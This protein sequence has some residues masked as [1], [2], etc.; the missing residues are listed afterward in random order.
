MNSFLRFLRSPAALVLLLLF[1]AAIVSLPFVIFGQGSRG[2]VDE[3]SYYNLRLASAPVSSLWFLGNDPLSPRS[4]PPAYT[5]YHA[6]LSV[7]FTVM[8]RAFALL[9]IA[10]VGAVLAVLLYY[11]LLV[12]AGFA[13]ERAVM[14]GF[15]VALTPGF[16]YLFSS[17]TPNGLAVAVVLAALWVYLASRGLLWR[18]LSFVLFLVASLF[19][20]AHLILAAIALLTGV[21]VERSRAGAVFSVAFLLAAV[22]LLSSPWR[23]AGMQAMHGVSFPF[24]ILAELG[25]LPGVGVF[26]VLTAGIGLFAL[27]NR[28]AE[29]WPLYLLLFAGLVASYVVGSGAVGYLVFIGA[30]FSASGIAILLERKWSVDALKQLTLLLIACGFLFSILSF[31][32]VM[33]S[34]APSSSLLAA[35]H[36]LRQAPQGT[37]LSLPAYGFVLQQ[38]AGKKVAGD[39]FS[40]PANRKEINELFQLRNV[41]DAN[42][43]FGA[44]GIRYLLID[45]AMRAGLVWRRSDQGLLFVLKNDPAFRHVYSQ[46]GVDVWVFRQP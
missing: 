26:M 34:H 29:F 27:W 3:Q 36:W 33:P 1:S 12:R 35:S 15:I 18:I 19:G 44:A 43:A 7:M 13:P 21:L 24:G 14:A 10:V 20:V 46:D 40:S 22:A 4:L 2:L 16:V 41:G 9:L 38:V 39:P 5:P 11:A 23:A 30:I 8:P 28:R 42:R 25:F 45:D 6:L 32:A 17:F 31:L 37:V